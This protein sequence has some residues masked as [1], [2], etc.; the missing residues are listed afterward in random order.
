MA[1]NVR[2]TGFWYI[3]EDEPDRPALILPDGKRWSYG[4]LH[5]RAN[6][7]A[8]GLR[9]LGLVSGD[10]VVVAVQN[11]ETYFSLQLAAMQL[12]LYFTAANHHLTAT[13]LAYILTD[14]EASVLVCSAVH[15]ETCAEAAG[16][17]KLAPERCFVEGSEAVGGVLPLTRLF[18]GEPAT[19]PSDRVPGKLMSYTS[20]TTGRP[21]GI[22]RA[23]RPG[24]PSEIAARSTGYASGFG[25]IPFAG[26]NLVEGP[27][28]HAGPYGLAWGSLHLG[29]AQVVT[30]R[31]DA[32]ELL[33]LVEKYH[34]TSTS[35]VTTMFHR[36][37]R[38]PEEVRNRHDLSSLQMVM[39]SASPCPVETKQ[40]IMDWWGPV[41]WEMYGGTEGTATRVGPKEWLERPGTVGR[42]VDD[43]TEILILDEADV[44]CAPGETG[45]VF[46][47]KA[48]PFE[49]WKDEEKTKAAH[50]GGA[51]H[52]GDL[53]RLDEDGYLF[54]TGR[55]SEVI[56]SGG[57]NIYPAEI[58]SRLLAH[59]EVVDV[60]VIGAPDEEWGERVVAFVQSGSQR[61]H[62]DA[63]RE[64]LIAF[65]RDGLAKFKC[66]REV[67]L[68][69]RLPR[70]DNGKLY[71]KQ[72]RDSRWEGQ[73]RWI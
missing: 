49:Y 14:S 70:D 28:Y 33:A 63:F 5:A 62:D 67:E 58:E 51:F 47:R 21:K 7:L 65:C 18:E 41:L 32:E 22:R 43:K 34:V 68:R 57:V 1:P 60:A 69:E 2:R 73:G 25:L 26:V 35:L 13:E 39:H 71:R 56:I 50:Q 10:G 9:S 45:R 59:P 66:P 3:A 46:I 38:L 15:A 20:G 53:G 29:H 8:H 17:A 6:Q 12:G 31:F 19:P 42:P 37:L 27:L 61:A 11:G 4:D 16:E 48:H 30:T 54:L 36:L 64:E 40:K 44:E 72:L 23:I 55:A 52:L 24:D